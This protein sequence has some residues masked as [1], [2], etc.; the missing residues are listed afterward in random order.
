MRGGE[1]REIMFRMHFNKPTGPG[2]AMCTNIQAGIRFKE[3]GEVIKHITRGEDLMMRGIDIW[4]SVVDE[5][6]RRFAASRLSTY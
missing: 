1:D 2:T 3:D 6:S 5:T 4:G